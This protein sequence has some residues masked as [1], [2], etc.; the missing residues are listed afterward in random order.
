MG[1]SIPASASVEP[2]EISLA[3]V[4]ACAAQMERYSLVTAAV[5][6]A[7]SIWCVYMCECVTFSRCL[8]GFYVAS[9]P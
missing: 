1:S 3:S 7:V 6:M 2:V 4:P 8:C 9:T 5:A